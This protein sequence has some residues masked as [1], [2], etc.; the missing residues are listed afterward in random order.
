MATTGRPWASA[1]TQ[2]RPN[3]SRR[4]DSD[5]AA[6]RVEPRRDVG[7]E[8]GHVDLGRDSESP[9]FG[10]EPRPLLAFAENDEPRLAIVEPCEGAQ[11]RDEI[12]VGNEAAE[13]DDGLRSRRQGAGGERFW[14]RRR[15]GGVVDRADAPFGN[16]EAGDE[17]VA[18]GRRHRDRRRTQAGQ[19]RRQAIADAA[20][21]LRLAFAEAVIGEDGAIAASSQRRGDRVLE[22][23]DR[24]RRQGRIGAA[25]GDEARERARRLE[26]AA[27]QDFERDVARQERRRL[28]RLEIDRERNGVAARGEGRREPRPHALRAAVEQRRDVEQQRAWTGGGSSHHSSVLAEFAAGRNSAAASGR[29]PERRR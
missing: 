7:L 29:S 20:E 11:Q 21:Q 9:R 28:R 2:A 13:R 26:M 24:E 3:A 15:R 14:E 16:D 12:L 27:R 10:F 6:R 22:V 25:R 4:D 17:I 1:S 19:E 18:Q 8:A 23:G 5:E